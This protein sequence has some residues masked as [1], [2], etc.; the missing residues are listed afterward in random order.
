MAILRDSFLIR[1]GASPFQSIT[2]PLIK[3][4]TRLELPSYGHLLDW[5]GMNNKA[6][7]RNAPTVETKDRLNGHRLKLDLADFF[8]RIDYF[9]GCYHELDVVDALGHTLRPGDVF[10]EGGA[11]IGLVTI[12]CAARVG[13]SG[14]VMAF[15]PFPRVFERLKWHVETN[16]LSHVRL[17]PHALGDA[18]QTLTLKSPDPDNQAA[19]TLGAIPDRYDTN[20]ATMGEVR[21]VRGDDMI[22]P[23]DT[24]PLTIKLDVEG[25]ELR[26]LHGLAKTLETRLP[27]VLCE[28]N[29]EMLEVNGDSAEKLFDFLAGFGIEPYAIEREGFKGRHKIHLH[30]LP[31]HLLRYEK[32]VLWFSKKGAHWPRLKELVAVN[33]G[34]FRWEE[35]RRYGIQV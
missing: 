9:F 31:R 30:P 34:Y 16:R 23:A 11:N 21:V 25:F 15:E 32:D 27:A 20:V 17:F 14:S 3:A 28:V 2:T 18:E 8:Q 4:Y 12:F 5:W 29:S 1:T 24:R 7:W 13:P 19:C 10:L 33:R 6:T 35:L 22:D 26:A